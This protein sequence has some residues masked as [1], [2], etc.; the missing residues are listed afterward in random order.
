MAIFLFSSA[1]EYQPD[2][3]GL[4][5]DVLHVHCEQQGHDVPGPGGD[6]DDSPDDGA[7]DGHLAPLHPLLQI[8]QSRV[9]RSVQKY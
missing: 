5:D 8:L 9:I 1:T 7:D 6:H 3:P 4:G 2:D